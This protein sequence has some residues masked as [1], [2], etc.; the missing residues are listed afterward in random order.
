[1]YCPCQNCS[2]KWNNLCG[3]TS[4]MGDSD[5]CNKDTSFKSVSGLKNHITKKAKSSNLHLAMSHYI[6]FLSCNKRKGKSR[7]IYYQIHQ[8]KE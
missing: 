2:S 4:I 7:L 1:M 3:I 6:E 5:Y 8:K